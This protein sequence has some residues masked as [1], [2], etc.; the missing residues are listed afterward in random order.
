MRNMSFSMTWPQI[1]ERRKTVTRRTG[2]KF[3]KPGDRIQAVRKGMGLK[4]GEKVE[5]GPILEVVSVTGQALN[6]LLQDVAYG[7]K[8]TTKEGF[9]DDDRLMWPQTFVHW[10]C[11]WHKIKPTTVL[12]RIEFRYVEE[13]P[14]LKS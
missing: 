8:E 3:L 6:A 1:M 12:T 2:W 4:K 13:A 11:A 5:R 10:L 9:G 14:C 7:F